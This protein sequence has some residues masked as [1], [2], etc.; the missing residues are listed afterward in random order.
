VAFAVV[1]RPQLRFA[2]C[3]DGRV[4]GFGG[5]SNCDG[6]QSLA[7]RWATL[8]VHH[9]VDPGRADGQR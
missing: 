1:A 2:V 5:R 6:S 3:A 8:I 7:K 9:F 4:A